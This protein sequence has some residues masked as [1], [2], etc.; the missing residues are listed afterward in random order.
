[1]FLLLFTQGTRAVC[2]EV[3]LEKPR[4][5]SLTSP[6]LRRIFSLSESFALYFADVEYY[7]EVAEPLS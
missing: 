2:F 3:Q 7:L 6:L 4:L 5:L 1:M